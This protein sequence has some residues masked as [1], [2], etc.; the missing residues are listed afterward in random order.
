MSHSLSNDQIRRMAACHTCA[1]RP[2]EPC[3]FT[4]AEDPYGRRAYA[5]KMHDE[6]VIRAKQIDAEKE[7]K[8]KKALD[9]IRL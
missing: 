5:N 6:R 2:G 3:L 7:E 9:A 4:R 8:L 1:A